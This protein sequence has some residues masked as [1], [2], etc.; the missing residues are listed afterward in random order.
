MGKIRNPCKISVGKSEGSRPLGRTR[1]RWEDIRLDLRESGM[2]GY[3]LGSADSGCGRVASSRENGNGLS[4]Y[5]KGGD[6]VN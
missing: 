2:W 5:I 4:E 3:R 6:F 1:R